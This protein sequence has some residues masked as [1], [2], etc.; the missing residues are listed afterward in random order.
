MP[1]RN[2]Q[3]V[4][5]AEAWHEGVENMLEDYTLADQLQGKRM[6]INRSGSLEVNISERLVTL[7]REVNGHTVNVAPNRLTYTNHQK[8]LTE[9]N[10]SKV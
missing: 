4:T 9:V 1:H 5:L 6:E 8:R 10:F 2:K 3:E 7:L